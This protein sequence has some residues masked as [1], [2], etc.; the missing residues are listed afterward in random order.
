MNIYKNLAVLQVW[1]YLDNLYYLYFNIFSIGNIVGCVLFLI[2]IILNAK[3]DEIYKQNQL[4][5]LSN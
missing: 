4:K 1:G 2:G 3:F 5:S